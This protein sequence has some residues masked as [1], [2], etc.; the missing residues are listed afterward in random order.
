[1]QVQRSA[2]VLACLALSLVSPK[3]ETT[4]QT[5]TDTRTERAKL[6]V[7]QLTGI[8]ASE[9]TIVNEAA[10]A[11]TGITQFKIRDSQGNVHGISLDAAGNPVLPETLGQT[12]ED[13]DNRGFV[14]KL[15]V[16]LAEL[17]N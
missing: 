1:M 10:L 15:E 17:L 4:A 2:I 16:K 5:L 11:D 3:L 9:L 8:P 7:S 6:E 14:G 12:I 13:I